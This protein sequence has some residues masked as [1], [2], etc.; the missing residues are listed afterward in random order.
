[1]RDFASPKEKWELF[2]SGQDVGPMVSPL[3][4]DWSLDIPY[5]WP[6][7]E[8]EP[9]SGRDYARRLNEQLAMAKI[10]GYDPTFY[11]AADF[12]PKNLGAEPK[13]EIEEIEGGV[14]DSALIVTPYGDLTCVTEH[15]TTMRTLKHYLETRADLEK[16]IWYTR[17]CADYDEGLA[18]KQC[19]EA[20]AAV[21][22]KGMLGTWFTA[23]FFNLEN[24]ENQFYHFADWPDL[25]EELFHASRALKHRQM[26][27]Y[28][29]GGFDYLF[30]CVSGTEWASPG[31]LR[32]WMLEETKELI[33]KWRDT[34]GFILWHTC[35]HVK[36]LIEDGL[37][38]EL[39]PDILETLSEPPVGN[40]PSLKWARERID[41][42]IA[43]KGNMPLNIMLNGTP[44]EVR[45]EVSR[46]REETRGYRHIVGLS[47]D[48]F[49]DTPLANVL[50]MVE[51][52]RRV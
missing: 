30:Y 18:L 34:G 4:D 46:I 2:L 16:A 15:K 26:E 24:Q 35:G 9:P 47:D 5:H 25:A 22:D 49:H 10:C 32:K 36:K 50:A 27:T 21:K 19:G 38:N 23:P 13:H 7:D 37:Y 45:M 28:A 40:L 41:G 1:M 33:G 6:Y 52:A 44:E 43:T 29:K 42:A 39:R 14:R 48:I 17:Q 11:Y 3:C 20:R 8:P 31:F 12:I 51:E